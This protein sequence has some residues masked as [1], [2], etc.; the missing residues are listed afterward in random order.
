MLYEISE[1]TGSPRAESLGVKQVEGEMLACFEL[2]D[3]R[4]GECTR[5]R[6]FG[7]RRVLGFGNEVVRHGLDLGSLL[8]GGLVQGLGLWHRF[9]GATFEGSGG[10]FLLVSRFVL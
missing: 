6:I 10:M 8:C 7:L 3:L 2:L 1:F 9:G 4:L 5:F